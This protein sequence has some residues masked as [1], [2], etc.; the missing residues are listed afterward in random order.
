MES[1]AEHGDADTTESREI[2][3]MKE[4]FAKLLLGEDM[5]GSGQGVCS[6]LA[7]SNAITN[8]C[9]S[10]FG[11]LWRLEPLPSDKR[12][13]WRREMEWLLSVTDHIVELKPSLQILPNGARVEVMSCQPRSDLYVNLPALQK[14]DSMLLETLDGFSKTVFWYVDQGI[15][16]PQA[17]GTVSFQKRQEDKW[18][19]PVPRLPPGGLPEAARKLLSHKLESVNQIL[20]A[21]TAINS[22]T[23]ADM[24]VPESY[25]ETLPK[26]GRA[27]LGEVIYRCIT[28]ERF[29]SECLLDCLDLES[30]HAALDMANCVEAAI[31]VWRRKQSPKSTPHPSHCAARSSWVIVKDL[32]AY[33][34]K[35]ELL[36]ERA[37]SLLQSLKQRFPGLT[38]T[39]L[40]ATKIQY[41]KDVG[42]SILESYSRAMESLAFNIAARIEDLL[43][44]DDINKQSDRLSSAHRTPNKSPDPATGERTPLLVGSCHKPMRCGMGVKR[45]LTHYLVG[46]G[47]AN[48][49]GQNRQGI[50]AVSTRVS[51]GIASHR[52][53]DSKYQLI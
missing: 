15:V 48:G 10:V 41:N 8:L 20:K 38:Q 33:G 45:V 11:R 3:M 4:K 52:S 46:D 53:I 39:T 22:S 31:Y 37:E 40:D 35:S 34:D 16:A 27:C 12:S 17:D 26:T 1:L 7:I 21:S 2:E 44:V 30:E 42:K 36:A 43:Y 51:E 18:W 23:L 29:S 50:D 32:V 6:A 28:S 47:K 25:L 14:L 5:S 9:A 13:L 49:C 24:E 19:L